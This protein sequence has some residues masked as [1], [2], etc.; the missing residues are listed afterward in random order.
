MFDANLSKKQTGVEPHLQRLL[1]WPVR[2]GL[3]G[4]PADSELVANLDLCPSHKLMMMGMSE[5]QVA[6]QIAHEEEVKEDTAAIRAVI[7]AKEAEEQEKE[8][9]EQMAIMAQKQEQQKNNLQALQA[10][11]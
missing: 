8:F 1:G 6:L 7:A 3:P 4:N 11:E 10:Q 2:N 9:K 5:Q